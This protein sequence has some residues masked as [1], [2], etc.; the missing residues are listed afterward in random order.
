SFLKTAL[1]TAVAAPVV[2]AATSSKS[3]AQ[4]AN[5]LPNLYRG[6]NARNFQRILGDE[7]EHVEFLLG[8]LGGAA[9]P[10]PD[11]KMLEQANILAFAQT[12]MALENTGTGAY[13][14]AVPLLQATVEGQAYI[15]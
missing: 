4:T 11:F 6:W 2:L 7:D 13:L 8:A 10:K 12:S 1:T 9:R 14:G 5:Y 15:H 3:Q